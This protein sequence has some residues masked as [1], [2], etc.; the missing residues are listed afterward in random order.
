VNLVQPGTI[1]GERVNQLDV[2]VSK[3]LRLGLTRLA[4]NFDLANI[5]NDNSVLLF[6]NNYAAWQVPQN[7]H[8]ARLAKISVQLDF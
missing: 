8:D 4:V 2:R 3:L 5:L 6:N 1:Y 7:I